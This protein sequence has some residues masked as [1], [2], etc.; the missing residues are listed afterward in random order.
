[1]RTTLAL[2]TAIALG[3]PALNA[4]AASLVPLRSVAARAGYAYHWSTPG[5]SVVLSRPGTVV[6][7][8]PGAQV[9]QVDDHTEVA[10]AAPGYSR[11]D[12]Y[13]TKALAAH[14][15]ALA[16]RTS[17]GARSAEISS[18]SDAPAHGSITL[19]AR[20]LQGSEAI[21]VEGSAPAGAPVTITL[22][23]T[24]SSDLPT[25]VVSRHDV[26]PDVN[27]RFGAVIPIASAYERGTLLK[28]LAT[29]SSGVASASA[30]LVSGAP[31]AGA[32]VPLENH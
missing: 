10:D 24:V 28:V 19:E 11:G 31:N 6:V 5:S 27:G 18:T 3:L 21:D 16:R 12:L 23:A 13:V 15:E 20:Q 30:Q 22:L 14:L 7:L 2:T 32:S 8:R 4:G 26:V 29:S 9:Y 1:M 25:I 17:P